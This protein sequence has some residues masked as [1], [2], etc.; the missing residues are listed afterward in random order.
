[1]DGF[2]FVCYSLLIYLSLLVFQKGLT[3]RLGLAIGAVFAVGVLV[4]P[5]LNGFAPLIALLVL[6]DFWRARGEFASLRVANGRA[7]M[8]MTAM[9]A[10]GRWSLGVARQMLSVPALRQRF[11]IVL[12]MAAVAVPPLA[13]WMQRSYRLNQDL[14]YFNPVLKGHRILENPYY[15]YGFWAHLLDYYQSVWGGIFTTWWAHFGWLDTALPPWVYFLLRGLTFLAMAGLAYRFLRLWRSGQ[16]GYGPG[17][18]SARTRPP[19]VVW[20]FLAL[21]V[22]LPVVMLQ[23]YDLTFWWAF[24]N[25]RGLQGR[26]WLGTVVPMLIFFV[27]GLLAWLP[28]RFHAVAHNSLRLGMVLLN[29]VSLLGYVLPRYYL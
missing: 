7:S 19:L 1:V 24:G 17:R 3:W 20:L 27:A 9:G 26:Y 11:G 18:W 14:F 5:T 12:L 29:L 15:D 6:Y 25:G 10:A 21:A 13:W 28:A 23:Y 16:I 8:A 2:F 4:K 22:L